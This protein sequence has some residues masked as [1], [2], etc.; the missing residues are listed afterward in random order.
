MVID[1][2]DILPSHEQYDGTLTRLHDARTA[3]LRI[4]V[5]RTM[6]VFQVKRSEQDA[7]FVEST[8]SES[9]DGLIRRLV[10]ADPQRIIGGIRVVLARRN[11]SHLG[12]LLDHSC[13]REDPFR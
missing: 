7:F 3:G 8:V 5:S 10:S 2:N 11:P 9:N 1:E 12:H 13:R 4:R 6:V